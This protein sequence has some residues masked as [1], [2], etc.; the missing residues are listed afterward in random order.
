MVGNGQGS[1][2]QGETTAGIG[3][4]GVERRDE[5][6]KHCERTHSLVTKWIC[7]EKRKGESE[8]AR[9]L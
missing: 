6:E 1:H 7:R 2:I 9:C 5:S 4:T 3:D 8:T